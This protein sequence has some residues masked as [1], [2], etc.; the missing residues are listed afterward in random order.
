MTWDADL[1][2]ALVQDL[3]AHRGDFTDVGEAAAQL[4]CLILRRRCARSRTCRTAARSLSA[5]MKARGFET[6]GVADPA[7]MSRAIASSPIRRRSTCGRV[8]RGGAPR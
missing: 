8:V 5:S 7:A 3:R 4:V 6:V 1:M 2:R